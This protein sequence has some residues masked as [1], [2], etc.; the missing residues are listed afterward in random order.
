MDKKVVP[1]SILDIP[2]ETAT[3][4]LLKRW[5]KCRNASTSGKKSVLAQRYGNLIFNGQI[6]SNIFT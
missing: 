1:G 2:F 5:L 3:V 6:T 4:P